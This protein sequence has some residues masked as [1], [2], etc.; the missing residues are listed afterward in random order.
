MSTPRPED[1]G[2]EFRANFDATAL[3]V[4]ADDTVAKAA[5]KGYTELSRLLSWTTGVAAHMVMRAVSLV[6]LRYAHRDWR[7]LFGVGTEIIDRTQR[8]HGVG[9]KR[10]KAI[11]V[12]Y[13]DRYLEIAWNFNLDAPEVQQVPFDDA[14]DKLERR[15]WDIP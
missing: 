8:L 10:G 14:L 13:G 1:R 7:G 2:I 9:E 15:D 4:A 11:K 6:V 5:S 12:D 3:V